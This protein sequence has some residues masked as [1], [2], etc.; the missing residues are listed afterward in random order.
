MEEITNQI[1]NQSLDELIRMKD[2][3]RPVIIF[4]K[5]RPERTPVWYSRWRENKDNHPDDWMWFYLDETNVLQ[6]KICLPGVMEKIPAFPED[7]LL[8][9]LNS[10]GFS[11]K[12]YCISQVLM[13]RCGQNWDDCLD[14]IMWKHKDAH[15]RFTRMSI[16]PEEF[17]KCVLLLSKEIDVYTTGFTVWILV[18]PKAFSSVEE[19]AAFLKTYKKQ[20]VIY[21]RNEI[22]AKKNF[23]RKIG[24]LRYYRPVELA[25]AK[26][27]EIAVKFELKEEIQRAFQEESSAGES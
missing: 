27:S 26:T 21:A 7:M 10:Y 8:Q 25:F 4:R 5:K 13:D 23:I 16:F 2:Y 17:Q 6:Y 1:E 24:D 14:T 15:D 19:K 11:G 9:F 3:P 22:L 18:G 20:L 12:H